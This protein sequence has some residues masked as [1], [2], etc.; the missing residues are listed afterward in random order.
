[1][2]SSLNLKLD[3]TDIISCTVANG[4]KCSSLGSLIVPFQLQDRVKLIKTLVIPSLPH[5]L[6]LGAD[7][8]RAMEIVPDLRHGAW[9][10]S[11]SSENFIDSVAL[12]SQTTLT[13]D[14]S[15]QLLRLVEK[16]FTEMGDELGCTTLVEHEIKTTSPPIKQRYY[17]VSPIMQSHID[18]ELDKLISQ[19][20][21]EKS[22]SP[23]SS[24]IILVK[25]KDQS[26]RFCVDYR[27]L[28][29]V[30]ERDAYP[31]P[32]ISAT[33]D[34][35]RDAR[36]LSSLDIKS[37]YFQVPLSESSRP[38]TAF[39][40]PNRGLF[41]FRR[42]PMGLANSPAT[43]QRLIDRVLGPEL[44]PHVFVYL[45]DII[46]VT[47]TFE[48]HLT[49]LAEVFKRLKDANLTLSKEKCFFCRPELRYLGYVIDCNGLH[50]DP[51]KIKA[52]LNIPSPTCV[53]EVRRI[54]GL[55]S[56]Y[57]RFVPDFSTLT[58]P[59]SNLL[60][61]NKPFIWNELCENSLKT[62]K[63]QLITAP[64]LSCPDFSL[65]FTVQT[66]ASGFGIGAVLTQQ[67][68]EGEKVV[69]YLSRS[70]N[71]NE[72][73]Y[74]TT[75]RECLAVLWA[76]EKLRPYIEGS[77]FTVVTDH[78]SL[79]WLN[80][81]QSPTGRLARWAIR[82][83][84][85]DYDIV[86]RKGKEHVVPD[87]LSRSVPIIDSVTTSSLV[88]SGNNPSSHLPPTIPA[89]DKWFDK[90]KINVTK[91]PRKYSAWRIVN[92]KLYKHVSPRYPE[93]TREY[94]CWREVIPRN[95]RRKLVSDVHN[96]LCHPGVFKTFH[97]I[98]EDYYWPKMRADVAS[99]VRHCKVCQSIKPEQ[100][101]PIGLMLSAQ[102]SISRPFELIC[103]DLVGPLPKS[104][105]GHQHILVVA[106]C[107]S[108]FPLIFP[109]RT[110]THSKIVK[111]IEEQVF[112][113][114]GCPRAI[115]VD[116]GV[117]F[118]S[119]EFVKLMKT[120]NVTIKYTALYHPQA[121][122]CERINKVLKT[123]LR[124][125]VSENHRDWDIH[126]AKVGYAIRSTKHEVTGFTP[127][128]IN[129][130]REISLKGEPLKNDV[131]IQFDRSDINEQRLVGFNR[132]YEDVKSRLAKAY[133]QN[134]SF[135]IYAEDPLSFWK[136][137]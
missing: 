72:R 111:L 87:A 61:K 122:P 36:Y 106:D 34:K 17:P 37:A 6:I 88:P 18:K 25:K 132:I 8:W 45:D 23:W 104:K 82:L 30:T 63:E 113:V 84:Q 66:D 83:Q 129:F 86:H 48:K 119:K 1:M 124:S 120:Y 102:T 73:N 85:Y 109:L 49:I 77:K 78:Y 100:K 105:A 97:K 52:I 71:R 60:R 121:N 62:L 13:P 108:K 65:P 93:L 47:Q 24:P 74:S 112:L 10:F 107:F 41:Q 68:P 118:R 133:D 5:T 22:T 39:T 9:K 99:F 101:R 53:S 12:Q 94:E 32:Y 70:L 44:E 96:S 127:N 21:V 35:L 110:A 125:L 40:V 103:A 128:F 134:K 115:I 20:I 11:N 16:S 67:H 69:C 14:E 3:S 116:N 46:I 89:Q 117:Q 90:I 57:R 54:I 55:A 26:F 92:E 56:W 136:M 98:C 42:L 7:F 38:L 27:K 43:F 59:L 50:V 91:H 4:Q 123:M 19:N 79:V 76:I 114:F 135:M 33:L 80:N 130:G 28:N 58:A 126:L 81:L 64:V 29:K 15:K 137:N 75:E 2:L 51:D 31:L 95:N 131:P